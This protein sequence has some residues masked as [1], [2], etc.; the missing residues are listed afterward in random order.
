ME[1]RFTKSENSVVGVE[2][3]AFTSD[4]NSAEKPS[5]GNIPVTNTSYL[6]VPKRKKSIVQ[7][8]REALPRLEN[9][10]NSKKAVK[11]PSLGE[12]HGGDDGNK[13]SYTFLVYTV[14]YTYTQLKYDKKKL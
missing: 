14:H 3:S 8:T 2:N 5:N 12:L 6:Q 10:R 11:R 13:V 1:G 4:E 9:Y 7:W